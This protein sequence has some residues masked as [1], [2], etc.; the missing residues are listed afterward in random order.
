MKKEE[1][2]KLL[3]QAGW[4][5]ARLARALDINPQCLYRFDTHK[6]QRTR[7]VMDLAIKYVLS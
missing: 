3:Q 1:L 2:N 5:K 6:S 7:K 4:S